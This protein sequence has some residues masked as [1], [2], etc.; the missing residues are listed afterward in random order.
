MPENATRPNKFLTAT[1]TEAL[2][3]YLFLLPD[4]AGLAVFLVIPIGYAFYISLHDWNALSQMQWAGISNYV[5]LFADEQFWSSLKTT[6]LYTA[7]YVP[8]VYC[9]SLGRYAGTLAS[10][11]LLG[12]SMRLFLACE[13]NFHLHTFS[14]I[15]F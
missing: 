13:I 7:L 14:G 2:T 1:R 11:T 12:C 10:L 9:L 8:A 15:V 6:A 5:R 4:L 3:G